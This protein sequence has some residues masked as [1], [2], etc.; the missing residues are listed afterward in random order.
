MFRLTLATLTLLLS[1]GLSAC[2]E[3]GDQAVPP[4]EP[5]PGGA[6]PAQQ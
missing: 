4:Q 5:A 3:P 6:P 2:G 1:L